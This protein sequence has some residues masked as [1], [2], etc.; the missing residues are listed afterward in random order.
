MRATL[1]TLR[2]YLAPE[3]PALALAMVSTLAAAAPGR[4]RPP[5]PGG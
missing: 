2:P 3:W 4:A 5:P 1:R